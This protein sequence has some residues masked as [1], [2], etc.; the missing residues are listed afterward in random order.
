MINI[1]YKKCIGCELCVKD[2]QCN[3]IKIEDGKAIPLNKTCLNCGHCIAI[4]PQNAVSIDNYDM[5]D[6]KEY[7]KED[8]I[9]EPEKFLNSIKF[10]R[11]IR[12]FNNKPVERDKI[13]KIIEAGRFT[14]TGGNRQ[15]ISYIVIQEKMIELTQK[16][17]KVLYDIACS[18]KEDEHNPISNENKRYATLWKFMYRQSQRG[19]D[20]LFFNAPAMIIIL[21]DKN[22]SL[23][24]VVD[25]ALAASNME[26]MANALSLGACYNGFF[27]FA[28][29]SDVIRDYLHIPENKK[30]I[31]SLLIGYT[32]NKY[33]RTVPRKKVEIEWL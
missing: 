1:D 23:N 11:S 24:P 3:D 29:Q 20:T 32:D 33:L 12:Q 4:C 10:R 14:P 13:K 9:I 6:V 28:S 27:T 26:M 18:Y 17:V 30:I 8:F 2:C 5:N 15:P 25:G 21:G 16:T 31:T 7:H 19:K 22:L